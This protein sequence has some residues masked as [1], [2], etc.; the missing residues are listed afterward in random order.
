MSTKIGLHLLTPTRGFEC[1]G[2]FSP[3]YAC[4]PQSFRAFTVLPPAW[5]P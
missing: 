2:L 3:F 1:Y 4:P 5:K